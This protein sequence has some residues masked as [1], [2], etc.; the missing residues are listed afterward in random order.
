[1][2]LLFSIVVLMSL[3]HS[4]E[5]QRVNEMVNDIT[6]L[7]NNYQECQE[8]LK[9]RFVKT[10]Y[11]ELEKYKLLFKKERVNN[12]KLF[13]E[14]KQMIK[15]M[16]WFADTIALLE[17]KLKEKESKKKSKK[18]VLQKVSFVKPGTFHLKTNSNIYNK[19]NGKKVDTWEKNRTFTS[20]IRS[21]DWIKITGYFV[22]RKWTKAKKSLWIKSVN[23]TQ[24]N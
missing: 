14:Q 24:R 12:I 18:V 3:L 6:K 21:A 19:I 13:K 9:N 16:R 23:A 22:N 4:D 2:K 20:N 11:N 8:D 7:R 17:N 5:I 1:M 15:D 10:N